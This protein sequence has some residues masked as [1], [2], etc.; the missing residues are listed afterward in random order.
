MSS[1]QRS[2]PRRLMNQSPT[3]HTVQEAHSGLLVTPADF[4]VQYNLNPLYSAGTNG[5][6]QSIAIVNEANINIA[7]VNNYRALFGLPVNPPQVVIDGSDPGIDG[8]NSPYGRNGASLEAYLDVEVAGA[9]A[10][11]AQINL[12]I[13]DSTAIQDGLEMAAERAVYSNISPVLSLSFGQCEAT[14]QASNAFWSNLWEQAA[15]QGITV[16]V[17]T[18][19][20][21]SAACDDDN[22]QEYAVSGQ[23][24]NGIASTPYNVAVGGTDFY[25]SG[26][27]ADLATYWKNLASP[28]TSAP[29]ESLIKTIPEQ[30]FN[31]SQFGL[32]IYPQSNGSGTTIFA[33]GGGASTLGLAGASGYGPYPKPSWQTGTG[34]PADGVRDIP[35]VSLFGSLSTDGSYTPL[36][37]SDGDCQGGSK[38]Q[39]TG[40]GGTSA[41]APRVCRHDGLGEPEVWP[42]RAG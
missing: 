39:V 37:A 16:L 20:S 35:D 1:A 4:A 9:V 14:L 42:P 6:G 33:A 31:S 5:N 21:G 10:P 36:C 15:A 41:S 28:T 32:D 34:V 8:N 24:V 19:D 11:N 23:A 27:S 29:S 18:G 25:Y 40:V 13:A 22:S 7:Q 2:S 12:V 26:G 17:S 3:G 38:V 30:P